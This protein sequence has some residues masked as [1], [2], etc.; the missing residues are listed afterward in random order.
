MRAYAIGDIHGHLSELERAHRLIR[1]DRDRVG[2]G[3]APVVHVGDLCD[4]GPDTRG[5]IDLL[6]AGIGRGAPWVVLKG[7]HDRMMAR[8]LDP[9][10]RRDHRLREGLFWLHPSLGG[11]QTL[12]SYGIDTGT[13]AEAIHRAARDR[14]PQA[15]RAFVET[16]PTSYR[17]GDIFFCHAGVRPGVPLDHQVEDDLIWIRREFLDST[18]DHG[19]LVVHGHTPV[20]VV[21]HYGNRLNIDTGAG[22]GDPLSAVVLE[23]RRAWLLTEEGRVRV[24]PR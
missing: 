1:A 4:R 23:G 22:Y 17:L 8:F 24:D 16:L 20:E 3:D 5:V 9:V 19:A 7:N 13:D 2:D 21:S 14:V 15:H 6:M 11:K 10:P 18:A 12:A